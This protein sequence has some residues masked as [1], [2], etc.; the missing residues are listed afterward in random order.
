MYLLE[1]RIK[2]IIC[3]DMIR[4]YASLGYSIAHQRV[5]ITFIFIW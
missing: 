3:V 5:N 1:R 4:L 2:M